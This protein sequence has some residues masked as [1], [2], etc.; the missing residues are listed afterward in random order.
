MIANFSFLPMSI[1][2]ENLQMWVTV[3][4]KKSSKQQCIIRLSHG[5]QRLKKVEGITC[6]KTLS[7]PE[8]NYPHKRRI[9]SKVRVKIYVKL[10]HFDYC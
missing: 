4:Y 7:S 9:T 3:S 10:C 8:R 2:A 6:G 1:C 5:V